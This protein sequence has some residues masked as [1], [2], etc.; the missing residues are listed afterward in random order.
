MKLILD[1]FEENF[2]VCEIE[3]T[4][5]MINLDISLMPP[6]VM[7]GDC[8]DYENEVIT[9]NLQRTAETQE[10]IKNKMRSL[11]E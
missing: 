7:F 6:D 1:R 8:L 10:R 3:D 9:I 5:E 2:A 11:W 4:Q